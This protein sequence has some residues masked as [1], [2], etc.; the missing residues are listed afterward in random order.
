MKELVVL[1]AHLYK[2][3]LTQD[4]LSHIMKIVFLLCDEACGSSEFLLSW[5]YLSQELQEL[6][7]LKMP[8]LE[9]RWFLA[10]ALSYLCCCHE[11]IKS[12]SL[13]GFFPVRRRLWFFSAILR[14]NYNSHSS[15]IRG[16]KCVIFISTVWFNQ[17]S[18]VMFRC[19][20]Y[21]FSGVQ[22]TAKPKRRAIQMC[23][24]Q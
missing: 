14:I 24:M 23:W 12:E 4:S 11:C 1:E 13:I 19:R 3:S 16:S 21:G 10:M 7:I 8:F 5:I 2:M 6:R 18:N 9:L 22:H 20:F 17:F 15:Q